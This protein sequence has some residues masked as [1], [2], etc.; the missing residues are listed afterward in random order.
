[1][2]FPTKPSRPPHGHRAYHI[3][4]KR[5][6]DKH[7]D[8]AQFLTNAR[9]EYPALPTVADRTNWE[10]LA[11]EI[12]PNGFALPMPIGGRRCFSC[13][14]SL[15]FISRSK[16]KAVSYRMDDAD[17]QLRM[18]GIANCR[19]LSEA[20]GLTTIESRDGAGWEAGCDWVGRLCC[21]SSPLVPSL[22]WSLTVRVI[23]TFPVGLCSWSVLNRVLDRLW[24]HREVWKLLR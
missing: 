3:S 4:D 22:V 6:A 8:R 1:M 15:G 23:S 7:Y 21:R 9:V 16:L 10:G 18:I 12:G 20:G 24:C 14:G 11:A 19:E 17:A 5:G 2:R 13:S